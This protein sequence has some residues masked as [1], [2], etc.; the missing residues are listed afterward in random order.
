MSLSEMSRTE[1]QAPG[2]M[3]FCPG[4]VKLG[5]GSLQQSLH[6]LAN[7]PNCTHIVSC[8]E[9]VLG[10]PLKEEAPRQ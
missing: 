2:L 9:E 8:W 6:D 5:D 1:Y 4:G 10:C 7:I 3:P